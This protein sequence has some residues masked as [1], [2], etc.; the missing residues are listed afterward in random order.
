MKN[1]VKN[2]VR[3]RTRNIQM[4]G[5]NFLSF[6]FALAVNKRGD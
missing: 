5:K 4:R 2:E 1:V 6:S 3:K